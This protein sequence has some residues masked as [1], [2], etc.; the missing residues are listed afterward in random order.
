MN[1]PLTIILHKAP[2]TRPPAENLE[3]LKQA[4]AARGF[5]ADVLFAET[6]EEV[7][8]RA[9]EA[10][11]GG[12]EIIAGCGPDSVL[13]AVA[14]GIM[15]TSARLGV[16]PCGS[17]NHF[18]ADLGIP[19]D[20]D[21][22]LRVLA[23]GIAEPVDIAEVNRQVF[24]NNS[25]V[26]IYPRIAHEQEEEVRRSKGHKVKAFAH[27]MTRILRKYPSLTLRFKMGGKDL[28]RRTSFIFIGNNEYI[29]EGLRMSRREGL[30][31]GFLDIGLAQRTK[32]ADLIRTF[33]NAIFSKRANEPQLEEHRVEEVHIDS[34]TRFVPVALDGQV[35][36][37]R[38]PLR[39][40]IRP[41]ALEVMLPKVA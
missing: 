14:A 19:D 24:L 23:E 6:N 1:R 39:F 3:A 2:G 29:L 36:I 41:K 21:G 15:G 31:Q 34:R 7:V 26:G 30:T 18:A 11:L 8:E 13:S 33:A 27:A 28:V 16:L 10:A 9:H 4:A 37:M 20:L 40:K 35:K 12:A 5:A 17:F 25:T 38:T 32:R 22:A